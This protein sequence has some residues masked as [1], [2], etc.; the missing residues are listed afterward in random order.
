MAPA[1]RRH[2]PRPRVTPRAAAPVPP[3]PPA[4]DLP[5]AAHADEIAR[6]LETHPVVVV[7]GETGSGKSTQLPRICLPRCAR[8]DG[9]IAHTQPRRIAARE[10]AARVSS[11]LGARLG[12]VVGYKVR[13]GERTGPE[14]R[15][16]VVTDGML[17]AEL[18]RDRDLCA[19]HTIIVDEAHERSIN[20]DFLLGYLRNLVER[21]PALRVV[22]T[23]A[24]IDTARFARHFGDC[25]VVEVSG[26]GYPV[27]VLYRPREGADEDDDSL[28]AAVEQGVRELW[29]H[30]PGDVLVFLPGER[31]IRD[32]TE[33]LRRR[34]DDDVELL[35]LFARLSPAD[36][37]RIFRPSNGRRVVLSTNVA[38]TSLTVPGVRY[39]VDSG[40]A[41]VSRYHPGAKVQ[42]LPVERISRAAADQ[43][44]GR[45]GRVASG[46]CIRLY[47][48]DDYESRPAFTDPEIS[49][50]SLAA[51]LLRMKLLRLGDMAQFPFL[52][53]PDA[54]QVR[55][56]ERILTELG[57]LAD[58]GR[59]TR[60]GRELAALP[61]E[62][63][64]GRLLLEGSRRGCLAEALILAGWM[65]V[66]DPRVTPRE[67]IEKARRH[68]ASVPEAKSDI[69]AAI[70]LFNDYE[71]ERGARSRRAL[72]RWCRE[73]FLA[74]FRMR[75]WADLREQLSTLLAEK[76]HR[77]G[78]T[79]AELESIAV[80]MLSAFLSQVATLDEKGQWRGANQRIVTIH[81]ASRSFRSKPKWFVCA[82]LVETTRLYAR[83]VLPVKPVWIE[84]AAG[85]AMKVAYTEPWWDARSGNVMA[86]KSG[87][88][89]GLTVY[90]RRRAT[91]GSAEPAT[92]RAIFIN[93]AL[94]TGAME[95]DFAFA[96]H[97]R[98][99]LDEAELAARKWRVPPPSG[100]DLEEFFDAAIPP[101]ICSRSSLARWLKTDSEAESA[102]YIPREV[103]FDER[104]D[105]HER[106]FP[107]RIDAGATPLVV[108]Y[109]HEPG[110]D[111]DG[112][113]VS[114]PLPLVNQFR[115]DDVARHIPG[116]LN[117]YVEALLR[118]LPKP[119]R[120]RIQPLA[121]RAAALTE[122]VAASRGPLLEALATAL[123]ET[124][125][126][127]V[128]ASDFNPSRLPSHLRLRFELVDHDRGVVDA[129]RDFEAL[130][131]RHGDAASAA[132]ATAQSDG[133]AR[134]GLREW[135]VGDLPDTVPVRGYGTAVHAFPALVDR[136]G[137]VDLDLVDNPDAAR[138]LHRRGVLRLI[139]IAHR[140]VF[141]DLLANPA[142]SRAMLRYAGLFPATDMIE[143]FYDAVIESALGAFSDPP[144]TES[145][146]R[147]HMEN[148]SSRLAAK[149]ADVASIIER[150]VE[151]AAEVRRALD[152]VT[153]DAFIARVEARLEWL[154]GPGFPFAH[155]VDWLEH[156]PRF[157]QALASRVEK[158][159]GNPASEIANSAK[160]APFE[161]RLSP[162]ADA[163]GEADWSF[164]FLLEEYHVSVFAQ[165]LKTSVPISPKRLE[166]AWQALNTV[167][168]DRATRVTSRTG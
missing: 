82:A 13:F 73:S 98:A 6:L 109:R 124:D 131:Q 47:S 35:P 125:A 123:S 129:G 50:T 71:R 40:L 39:V 143:P 41:R 65:S 30:G 20:I 86:Y 15:V 164:R 36:Q 80:A 152:G 148:A 21:R 29:R 4:P 102:L 61:V 106:A 105:D 111:H 55:A 74:P 155:P 168:T 83:D 162:A 51:V 32:V 150:A 27:E 19:Y 103:L 120:R 130:R 57:A 114:V 151:Q 100:D 138:M 121:A 154:V 101:G 136:G 115:P 54:R 28:P 26:R 157:T 25:P 46:I 53:V 128:Q 96:R 97:N 144:R 9:M 62:P 12:G 92:A 52:D 59:L 3:A 149:G 87:T 42:R 160:I 10:V 34:M 44:K 31:E 81:P 167:G 146:F 43:R 95:R 77:P 23:S 88:L 140:R 11:E 133:F 122:V 132:F 5:I 158:F 78:S 159:A 48:Q 60:V 2:R 68:H 17:L 37:K 67:S 147:R 33:H 135:N 79:P 163:R 127:D 107:A 161:D 1:R 126:V 112:V 89:Y 45:C 93:E 139:K 153:D 104:T 69:E 7:A 118:T 90:A 18:E 56:A 113:N 84:R 94:C 116:W 117:E 8:V 134:T 156:L 72:E 63:R 58:D 76:G 165:H 16:K 119:V 145:A 14:T 99:L 110:D 91:L 22:V 108:C 166:R 38:E 137:H 49:R 64:I 70:A 141:K 75:E 66:P 142:A 85:D 24:T